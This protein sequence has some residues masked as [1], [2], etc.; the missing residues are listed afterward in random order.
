MGIEERLDGLSAKFQISDPR[1]VT[2]SNVHTVYTF[3]RVNPD[4]IDVLYEGVEQAKKYIPNIG[5]VSLDL[6]ALHPIV[7]HLFVTM[8]LTEKP[9]GSFCPPEEEKFKEE[10]Y[11]KLSPDYRTRITFTTESPVP[12]ESVPAEKS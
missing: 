7:L 8:H 3:L 12:S 5:Q 1:I 11:F 10:W 9:T 4:L 6:H 2:N